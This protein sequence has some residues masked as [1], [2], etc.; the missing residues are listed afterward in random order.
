MS[1]FLSSFSL[2]YLWSYFS[3]AV[4]QEERDQHSISGIL[5]FLNCSISGI[6]FFLSLS[7]D[8][9]KW[10]R[11]YVDTHRLV[12]GSHQSWFGASAAVLG[13]FEI[14][15]QVCALTNTIVWKQITFF[16]VCRK[17]CSFHPTTDL[18]K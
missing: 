8:G 9:W 14:D 15:L 16:F 7:H 13:T 4:L 10:Q 1:W 12:F 11:L 3:V 6:L 18:L 5:F 2:S 17:C